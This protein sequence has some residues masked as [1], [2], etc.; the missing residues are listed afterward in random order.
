[1]TLPVKPSTPRVPDMGDALAS[2]PGPL[3]IGVNL[4][5][6]AAWSLTQGYRSIDEDPPNPGFTNLS[7]DEQEQY[8]R[9]LDACVPRDSGYMSAGRPSSAADQRLEDQ[10]LALIGRAAGDAGVVK[11]ISGYPAC[12]SA[13][14]FDVTDREGLRALMW[15][16]L[17]AALQ[18]EGLE[19]PVKNTPAWAAATKRE[20]AAVAADAQCRQRAHAAAIAVIS[21]DLAAFETTNRAALAT[22]SSHWHD[23]NERAT[24][25]WAAFE[26]ASS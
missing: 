8:S 23:L 22:A 21:A 13:Q 1:L 6:T 4:A 9:Q 26:D 7:A 3:D 14:G 20:E 12:M 11:E 17:G 15:T 25:E 19:A 18:K 5:A 24:S 2:T 10:F 16:E